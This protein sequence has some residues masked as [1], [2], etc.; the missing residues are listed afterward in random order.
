MLLNMIVNNILKTVNTSIIIFDLDEV[1]FLKSFAMFLRIQATLFV[2]FTVI[3]ICLFKYWLKFILK[4]LVTMDDS[5]IVMIF[6][7]Q[8]ILMSV[9]FAI[10]R[11]QISDEQYIQ[12]EKK[13]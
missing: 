6:S 10:A 4:R 5:V 1:K 9:L 3:E 2:L 12:K 8:N 7:L 11:V 13:L